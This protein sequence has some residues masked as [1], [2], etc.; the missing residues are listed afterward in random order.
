[1]PTSIF[2]LV[3][4]DHPDP[5]MEACHQLTGNIIQA[6][7]QPGYHEYQPLGIG[8]TAMDF[9]LNKLANFGYHQRH[10]GQPI[11]SK[12]I[13]LMYENGCL[14]HSM[15]ALRCNLWFGV[16][17]LNTFGPSFVHLGI[18]ADTLPYRR[19]IDMQLFPGFT[20]IS[21][22]VTLPDGRAFEIAVYSND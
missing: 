3:I 20:P 19:E 14:N 17:N 12:D 1:M 8:E 15:V 4:P 13:I 2:G 21:R 16:N 7:N 6:I 18:P 9:V 11:Q 10:E 5:R 22:V